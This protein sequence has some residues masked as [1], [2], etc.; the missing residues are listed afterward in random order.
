MGNTRTQRQERDLTSKLMKITV[1]SFIYIHT[2]LLSVII[3]REDTGDPPPTNHLNRIPRVYGTGGVTVYSINALVGNT[4][5]RYLIS[6]LTLSCTP[7]H[8]HSANVIKFY[9]VIQR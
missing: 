8:F 4:F 7:I 1:Y 3:R 6:A 5:G 9:R 2:A